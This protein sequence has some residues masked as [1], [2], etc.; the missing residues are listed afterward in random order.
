M[1]NLSLKLDDAVFANV[2]EI[3][4]E[5]NMKRNRYINEAIAHYNNLHRRRLMKTQLAEE[6]KVSYGSSKEVL[7]EIEDLDDEL[8]N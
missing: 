4:K 5:I 8:L 6:S 2:E 1:K 7:A 3:V